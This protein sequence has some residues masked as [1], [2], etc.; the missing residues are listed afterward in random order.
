MS[1]NFTADT[2]MDIDQPAELASGEAFALA[3]IGSWKIDLVDE[4]RYWTE[5]V[6]QI[7]EINDRQKTSSDTVLGFFNPDHRK[8]LMEKLM[9]LRTEGFPYDLQLQITTAKGNKK[10][11]RSAAKAIYNDQ[12]EIIGMKGVFQDIQQF[13]STEQ[14]LQDSLS[15]ADNQ[16]KQLTQF[17]K[18]ITNSLSV[19]SN[20]FNAL[21][22]S[23]SQSASEDEQSVIM[24]EMKKVAETLEKNIIH[25]KSQLQASQA[26]HNFRSRIKFEDTF[27]KVIQLLSLVIAETG[28]IIEAD[29]STAEELNYIPAYLESIFLNLISNAI[30]FRKPGTAPYVQVRTFTNEKRT[31]LEVKDNGVGIDLANPVNDVFALYSSPL[32]PPEAKGIGLFLVRNQVN[33]LGGSVSVQS[34]PGEGSTFIVEL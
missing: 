6:F 1:K 3:Q 34:K 8:L 30:K 15:L 7:F 26:V 24:H 21:L 11:V 33:A 5:E 9:L 19:H 23:L 20:N 31:I 13:K 27:D 25:L 29:F 14:Q 28:T 22:V 10:W 17:A 2:L 18:G 12:K 16:N 4:K 32:N